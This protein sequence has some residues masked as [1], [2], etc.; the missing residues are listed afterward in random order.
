MTEAGHRGQTLVARLA[1]LALQKEM[2]QIL[3]DQ[4]EKENGRSVA[5][6]EWLQVLMMSQR[7]AWMRELT[8]LITDIDILTE[9]ETVTDPQAAVVRSEVERLLID[10]DESSEFSKHY[11]NLLRAESH[12]LLFHGQMK[13]S[14]TPL[15]KK[16]STIEEAAAERKSWNELHKTQSRKKRN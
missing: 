7:Y 2:I 10:G 15:P 6:A 8:S 4:F 12:L 16:A 5:P 11:K 3:K 13:S 1:L 9:L 14:I